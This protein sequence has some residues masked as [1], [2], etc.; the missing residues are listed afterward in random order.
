[1][2]TLLFS[3]C[4]ARIATL[5]RRPWWV[6]GPATFGISAMIQIFLIQGY[7]GA[8]LGL[9][10]SYGLMT[11]AKIRYPIYKGPTLQGAP[12]WQPTDATTTTHSPEPADFNTPAEQ[13]DSPKSG[14]IRKD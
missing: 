14:S 1:M 6:W 2:L 5:E 7:W 9:L 13:A 11:W 4:M 10:C 3:I 8:V 12:K